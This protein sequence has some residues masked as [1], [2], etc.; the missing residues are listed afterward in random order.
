MGMHIYNPSVS[1]AEA[2]GPQTG[3]VCQRIKIITQA[4]GAVTNA[5]TL[6]TWEAEAGQLP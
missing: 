3:S 2:E 4:Y 5:Y 1:K 6:I